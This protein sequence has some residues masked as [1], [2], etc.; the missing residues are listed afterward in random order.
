AVAGR[1][2][3]VLV[4]GSTAGTRLDD[5][6]K[7]AARAAALVARAPCTPADVPLAPWIRILSG[8]THGIQPGA[9]PCSRFERF[10]EILDA[11]GAAPRERSAVVVLEDLHHADRASLLLLEL[12]AR[13]LPHRPLAVIAAYRDVSAT[14]G[15]PLAESLAELLHEP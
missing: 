13:A 9:R 11:L 5:A 1:G 12:L 14:P 4:H 10:A 8:L 3:L 6:V 7:H 15:H 2:Q